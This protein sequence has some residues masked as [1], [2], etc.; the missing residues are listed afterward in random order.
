MTHS[1]LAMRGDLRARVHRAKRAPWAWRLRNWIRPA[2]WLGFLANLL[3]RWFSAVTKIPTMT[4]ELRARV[5]TASGEVIDFG[6][7]SFRYVTDTGVA[8]L[9]DDWDDDTTDITTMNY[10]ASGTDATGENQTDSALGTESTTITDRA[11]GAKTQPAA[12]QI[13]SVGTQSYTGSGA[14]V[15]HGLF[16]VVTESSGVMWDRSV[17][18]AINVADGDSIEWTYTCTITAGS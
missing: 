3:A 12:N 7:L 5:I 11:T 8:F 14:I 15:E 2:F 18:S 4:A 13:R 1:E 9:V 10:H 6:I 16:S 17:F